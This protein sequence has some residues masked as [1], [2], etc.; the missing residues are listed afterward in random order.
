MILA[1]NILVI[2]LFTFFGGRNMKH[3]TFKIF[4]DAYQQAKKMPASA[5]FA[6]DKVSL[7]D[8]EEVTIEELEKILAPILLD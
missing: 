6:N 7:E 3:D 2:L 5:A 8:E 1:Y 4:R